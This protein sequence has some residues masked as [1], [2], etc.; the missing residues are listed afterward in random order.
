MAEYQEG[1][2]EHGLR[3]TLLEDYIPS[4][5]SSL[6][7]IHLLVIISNHFEIKL[8]TIQMLP[9]FHGVDNENPYKHLDEFKEMCST[10]K[11]A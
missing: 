9:I 5:Y 4:A 11:M 2:L 1:V 10:M 6:S 8:S 7:W 3:T